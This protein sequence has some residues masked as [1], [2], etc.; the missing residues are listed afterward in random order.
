MSAVIAPNPKLAGVRPFH[1]SRDEYYRLG[2]LG[3]FDGR[4]VE[5][6]NGEIVEMSPKGWPH[7]VGC[8][9]AAEVMEKLF[10][11]VGWVSRQEPLALADSDPEP[12]VSVLPGRF[13]DY[14]GHPQTASL[15]I[16]VAD[17]T[18]DYD[19]TTK[20]ELYATASVPDYWVLDVVGRR[21]L[22]FRDPAPLPAGLG[23]TAYRTHLTLGPTDSIA[24]LAAPNSAVK[25]ADL[26][27]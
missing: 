16:E 17:T 14:A 15:V 12:D 22:V 2:E 4:R 13:D 3:F 21:L 5:R 18:L 25:V 11:G 20:A 10:A 7:V 23:A 9:K 8:R 6:I 19:T 27:P 1:W 26:L 24:P